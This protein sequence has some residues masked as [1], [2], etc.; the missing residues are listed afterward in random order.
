MLSGGQ[1]KAGYVPAARRFIRGVA[2]LVAHLLWAQVIA[3]SSPV[4]P[5][6]Q[7]R[8]TVGNSSDLLFQVLPR[9]MIMSILLLKIECGGGSIAR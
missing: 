7:V 8:Y 6:R 9:R 3:G 2:Q 5:I 1:L 4:T